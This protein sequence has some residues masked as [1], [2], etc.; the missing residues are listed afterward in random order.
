RHGDRRPVRSDAGPLAGPPTTASRQTGYDRA[1]GLGGAQSAERAGHRGGR[2][3]P[4]RGLAALASAQG[5]RGWRPAHLL[6]LLAGS[7]RLV[8][9]VQSPVRRG[10]R[11]VVARPGGGLGDLERLP[12]RSFPPG[13]LSGVVGRFTYRAVRTRARDMVPTLP[14]CVAGGWGVLCPGTI[15]PSPDSGGACLVRGAGP[16]PRLARPPWPRLPLL[17]PSSPG[18]ILPLQPCR[19][20]LRLLSDARR[21]GAP[22]RRS[23]LPSGAASPADPLYP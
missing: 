23:G 4:L 18:S 3:L 7:H 22:G 10:G 20:R 15:A 21:R 19:R 6:A 9:G 2:F 12:S 11:F 17:F 16:R 1:G 5:F 8:D 13:R 14:A